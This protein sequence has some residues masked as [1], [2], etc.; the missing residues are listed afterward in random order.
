MK[1]TGAPISSQPLMDRIGEANKP[2]D[3]SGEQSP[4]LTLLHTLSVTFLS[5]EPSIFEVVA[6]DAVSVTTRT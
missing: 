6:A 4:L 3:S 1:M 2:G 5:P